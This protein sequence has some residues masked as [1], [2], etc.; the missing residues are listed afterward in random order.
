MV[1]QR[2]AKKKVYLS[3]V[4]VPVSKTNAKVVRPNNAV[5]GVPCRR[6]EPPKSILKTSASKQQPADKGQPSTSAECKYVLPELFSTLAVSK[7]I[8]RVENTQAAP[9]TSS[10]QLTPKSKKQLNTKITKKLNHQPDTN[11]YSGLA[12]VGV[13]D[14]QRLPKEPRAIYQFTGKKDPEPVL[15]DYL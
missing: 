11:V 9:I 7:K 10:G 3:D 13:N 14:N 8:E 4:D 15:S 5:Q 6:S 12:P 1:K 2:H